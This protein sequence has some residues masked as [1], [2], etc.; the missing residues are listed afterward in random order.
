MSCIQG[1]K[2]NNRVKNTVLTVNPKLS[3]EILNFNKQFSI[4]YS[5]ILC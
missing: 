2:V 5:F 1:K 4:V 3:H